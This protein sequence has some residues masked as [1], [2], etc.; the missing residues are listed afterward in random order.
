MWD[1]FNK[2]K[3]PRISLDCQV[4]VA[5]QGSKEKLLKSKTENLGAGGVCLISEEEV[6]RF[7]RCHF[8]IQLPDAQ[9]IDGKGKVVWV[10][11]RKLAKATQ[12]SYDVGIEFTEFDS[13][14]QKRLIQYL[15]SRGD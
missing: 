15:A 5:P 8:K 12:K 4:S 9:P 6:S 1:G 13:D 11:P 3:F 2:R 10:I 7:D 14:G